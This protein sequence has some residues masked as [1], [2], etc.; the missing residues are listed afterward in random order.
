MSCSDG[1]SPGGWRLAR[2]SRLQQQREVCTGPV[3][4]PRAEVPTCAQRAA[5]QDQTWCSEV[6][7]ALRAGVQRHLCPMCLACF[8]GCWSQA[9]TPMLSSRWAHVHS[10][11]TAF[12]PPPSESQAQKF[13]KPHHKEVLHSR[14]FTKQSEITWHSHDAEPIQRVESTLLNY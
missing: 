5:S 6:V 1:W 11:Q 7:S 14:V 4:C 8:S 13:N 10:V 3:L 2:G 9:L 12:L